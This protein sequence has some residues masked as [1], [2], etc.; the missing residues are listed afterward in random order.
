MKL[1]DLVIGDWYKFKNYDNFYKLTL[2]E[3]NKL[4][5]SEKLDF[6][7]N[8]KY[9]IIIN[10]HNLFIYKSQVESLTKINIEDI[11]EYLPENHPD[12][13]KKINSYE[14]LNLILNYY[15]IN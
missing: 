9:N 6:I 11:Q 5:F 14:Y 2:I 12:K 7:D 10:C 1:Q 8:N 3:K 4:Y 15:G 13:I